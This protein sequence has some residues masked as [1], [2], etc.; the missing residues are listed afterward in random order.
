M[1]EVKT[2]VG[3]SFARILLIAAVVGV[4]AGVLLARN[5]NDDRPVEE[6]AEE[7]VNAVLRQSNIRAAD[8]TMM[9]PDP[10]SLAGIPP[11]PGAEPRKLTSRGTLQDTPMAISWF[12]TKDPPSVVLDFYSKAFSEMKHDSAVQLFSPTMGYV[13]WMEETTD[14]GPGLLHM[15][16]VT[17]QYSNTMVLLSASRP[18]G[19]LNQKALLPGGLKLPPG[20]SKPQMVKLG[21]GGLS[22]DVVYSRVSNMT[23]PDL[24]SFFERQ[25]K[26]GGYAITE[27]TATAA[28]F[29]V[30]GQKEGMSVVVAARNEGPHLSVVL[31]Y[32]RQSPQE[33]FP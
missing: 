6:I 12:Q 7:E 30:V 13:G 3:W 1:G 17:R 20:A 29:S 9:E 26:E 16:S 2:K 31:T 10:R 24:V 23:G 8:S 28:Q 11:Y 15:V 21:E 4:G 22:N 5:P 18:E 33:T 14:G 19:I 25:F 27:S 32:S